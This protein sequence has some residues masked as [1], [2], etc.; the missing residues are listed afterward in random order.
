MRRAA[1][2]DGLTMQRGEISPDTL[3]NESTI[4]RHPE[5][6]FIIVLKGKLK[7]HIDGVEE[8]LEPR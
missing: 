2:L 5:D 6:Q 7:M 4:H 1:A 8:W 3:F